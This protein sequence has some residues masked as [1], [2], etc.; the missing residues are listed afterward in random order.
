M[1]KLILLIG[2]LATVFVINAQ[3][4]NEG[5]VTY[6]E[7]MQLELDFDDR[8]EMQSMKAMIPTSRSFNK[9]LVF[10]EGKSIY[11]N[12]AD[13]EEESG[14]INI[15]GNSESAGLQLNIK[16][17]RPNHVIFQDWQNEKVIQ[18]R[19]FMGRT[20][21]IDGTTAK[22][23]KITSEEKEIAGYTCQKAILDD[24]VLIEAWFTKEIPVFSGPEA[25]GKLPGLILELVDTERNRVIT[26]TNISFE[27][28]NEKLT[29]PTK[30]KR[31]T[32][33]KFMEIAE[34]K[35][36]EMRE[37]YGGKGNMIMIKEEH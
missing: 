26:A 24:T 19:D 6:K 23:W 34:Q 20:F 2:T 22:K 1:K 16:I 15:G 17:D 37:E 18:K 7:T 3:E 33:E 8:P 11:R 12:G 32:A 13:D 36:Q 27:E 31:V 9:E 5:K 30:G 4:R 21:L 10:K 28:I 35:L 14:D 29:P 25:Y